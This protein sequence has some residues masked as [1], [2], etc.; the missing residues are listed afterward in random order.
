VYGEF[1][2]GVYRAYASYTLPIAAGADVVVTADAVGAGGNA[3]DFQATADGTA[4]ASCALT[5]VDAT[6]GSARAVTG[7]TAGNDWSIAIVPGSGG[8]EGVN[9]SE[10]TTNKVVTVMYESGVSTSAHLM[11]AIDGTTNMEKNGD[12]D[13]TI[14]TGK[15]FPE[16]AL[17]GGTAATWAEQSGTPV[18][19]H[20]HFTDAVTTGTAAKTAINAVTGKSM[21]ATGGD[22][23]AMAAG[24]AVAKQDLSGGVTAVAVSNIVGEDISSVTLS[25]LGTYDVVFKTK[26]AGVI[27]CRPSLKHNSA[28]TATKFKVQ[29]KSTYD[30]T[31]RKLTLVTVGTDSGNA[32]NVPVNANTKIQLNV[33]MD[34]QNDRQ[35][36]RVH[37]WQGQNDRHRR[38]NCYRHL[39]WGWVHRTKDHQH[40]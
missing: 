36:C 2:T 14:I 28:G 26:W 7:G 23:N 39:D 10:D 38:G 22:A 21:T 25:A 6:M 29:Y 31:N 11:T 34:S 24:D 35:R 9:V 17:T 4:K 37:C 15:Y 18:K 27:S 32:V 3:L 12:G 1:G 33:T 5:D 30:A 40:G 19:M 8:G 13:A 20:L 16:T